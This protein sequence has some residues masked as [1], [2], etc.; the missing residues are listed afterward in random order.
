MLLAFVKM[1]VKVLLILIKLKLSTIDEKRAGSSTF[2]EFNDPEVN[3]TLIATR[4]AF[5]TP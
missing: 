4:D 2:D 5:L 1:S 3:D